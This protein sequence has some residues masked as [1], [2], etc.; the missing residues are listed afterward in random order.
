MTRAS[1]SAT[2]CLRIILFEGGIPR[3]VAMVS[4]VNDGS[5]TTN[6][7][8]TPLSEFRKIIVKNKIF[9]LKTTENCEIGLRFHNCI[10]KASLRGK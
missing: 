1:N 3:A 10:T 4:P 9:Y 5:R 7:P 6:P 2:K 8:C